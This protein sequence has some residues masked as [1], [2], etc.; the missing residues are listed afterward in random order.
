MSRIFETIAH[1]L[2]I[3]ILT[4]A[5]AGLTWGLAAAYN[6]TTNRI[7]CTTHNFNPDATQTQKDL[8]RSSK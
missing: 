1:I 4:V 3:W 5:A 7:D 6:R 8:C 2:M